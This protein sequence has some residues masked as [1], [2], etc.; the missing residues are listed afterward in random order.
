MGNLTTGI[1][2]MNLNQQQGMMGSPG[3]QQ[4]PQGMMGMPVG[5]QSP[6]MVGMQPQGMMGMRGAQSAMGSMQTVHVSPQT[7]YSTYGAK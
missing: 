1:G 3:M 7:Q 2:Q 5:M 4:Q 6:G